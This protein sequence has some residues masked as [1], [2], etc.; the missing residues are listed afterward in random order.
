MVLVVQRVEEHGNF[1]LAQLIPIS[2][3]S[4]LFG[5]EIDHEG[6][7]LNTD[8]GRRVCVRVGVCAA[9]PPPLYV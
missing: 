8:L 5:F 7:N 4:V 3:E 9:F 6:R 1:G 2:T